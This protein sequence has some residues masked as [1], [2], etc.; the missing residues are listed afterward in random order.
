MLTSKDLFLKEY[1]GYS[2]FFGIGLVKIE[3]F[4]FH[5]WGSMHGFKTSLVVLIFEEVTL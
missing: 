2:C 5:W 1:K 3:E 4:V